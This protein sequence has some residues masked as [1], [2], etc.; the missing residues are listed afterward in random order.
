MITNTV[1]AE[2]IMTPVIQDMHEARI[3]VRDMLS[4]VRRHDYQKWGGEVV[5]SFAAEG[6]SGR[7]CPAALNATYLTLAAWRE[8]LQGESR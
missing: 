3:V 5:A 1:C 6:F 2:H 4:W 7:C 8:I